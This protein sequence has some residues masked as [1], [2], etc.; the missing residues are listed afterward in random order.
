MNTDYLLYSGLFTGNFIKGANNLEGIMKIP[1]QAEE[2][3]NNNTALAVIFAPMSAGGNKLLPDVFWSGGFR[4]GMAFR[5]F[6]RS[7]D[8][9]FDTLNVLGS[10]QTLQAIFGNSTA[11]SLIRNNTTALRTFLTVNDTGLATILH[12][13]PASVLAA[14]LTDSGLMAELNERPA[15]HDAIAANLGTTWTFDNVLLLLNAPVIGNAIVTSENDTI[16]NAIITN[17]LTPISLVNMQKLVNQAGA[18]LAWTNTQQNFRTAILSSVEVFEWN[19]ANNKTLIQE[20]W[21]INDSMNRQAIFNSLDLCTAFVTDSQFALTAITLL[22]GTPQSY[23]NMARAIMNNYQ[24]SITLVN[25]TAITAANRLVYMSNT[26]VNV[27]ANASK[28]FLR[29]MFE[30]A[31]FCTAVEGNATARTALSNSPFVTVV[32]GQLDLMDGNTA[33]E[34]RVEPALANRQGYCYI[35]NLSMVGDSSGTPT[36]GMRTRA[37]GAARTGITRASIYNV[38][39]GLLVEQF[40]NGIELSRTTAG[41]LATFTYRCIDY[42]N[43]LN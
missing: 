21:N 39:P 32:T 40:Y 24:A 12:N 4:V 34:W 11:V 15:F 27:F 41:S 20:I 31:T 1:E 6:V 22:A 23:I 30:N 26:S 17:L 18:F 43:L 19:V 8:G 2:L 10:L 35:K 29:A 5:N 13:A 37:S 16:R 25:T 14:I 28:P 42:I 3:A 36:Y 33:N 9:S 7:I 38:D